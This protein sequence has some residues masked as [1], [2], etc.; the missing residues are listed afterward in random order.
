M[1]VQLLV[2]LVHDDVVTPL[3]DLGLAEVGG[4]LDRALRDHVDPA[5][6]ATVLEPEPLARELGLEVRPHLV[7]DVVDLLDVVE[8]PRQL[9]HADRLVDHAEADRGHAGAVELAE[10]DL[11]NVVALVTLLATREVLEGHAARRLLLRRL[12]N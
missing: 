9:E 2:E 11:A 4:A 5:D 1:D 6:L 7:G 3:P 12:S 8:H 10:L